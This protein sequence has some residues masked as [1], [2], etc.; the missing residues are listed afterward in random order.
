MYE[1]YLTMV[2]PSRRRNSSEPGVVTSERHKKGRDPARLRPYSS[3][4]EC[5]LLCY[6]LTSLRATS[7]PAT[8]SAPAPSANSDAA[9]LPPLFGSSFG[10]GAGG[11]AGAPGGGG[12]G[13]A[14]G[15]GGG[16]GGSHGALATTPPAFASITPSLH[17]ASAFA[18]PALAS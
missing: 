16:G 12:G 1:V 8:N 9:P 7:P 3:P 18:P 15:G 4:F 6:Y 5:S 11:G 14:L 17:S 10:A 2:I 13:A